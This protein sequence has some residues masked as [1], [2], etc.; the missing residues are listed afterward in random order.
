MNA[1][2]GRAAARGVSCKSRSL[3]AAGAALLVCG[4]LA[5][6]AS[7]AGGAW[8]TY[9]S[10]VHNLKA[11]ESFQMHL[12]FDQIPVRSWKL[13]IEGDQE[14]CDLSVL[15]VRG[16]ALVY[17]RIDESRHEVTVPWGRDEEAI[18]VVT[19]RNHDASFTVSV[20]G[21]PRDQTHAAYGYEVNR[22]LDA[23][24][25]GRRLD[26]EEHCR[27]ALQDDPDDGVA[28]VLLAGFLRERRLLDEAAALVDEA[29]AGD[30]PGDMRDVAE[31]LRDDL[32]RL[33]APL[34]LP[35]QQG[36]DKAESALRDQKPALALVACDD[37]LNGDLEL[38]AASRGQLLNLRGRALA[39]LDRNFE[40]LDAFTQALTFTRDRRS[41]AVVYHAM[42]DLFLKIG[43][44]PQADSS[45]TMALEIGLP[46]GL[47]LKA[48]ES[49]QDVRKRL[50]A[51]R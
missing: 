38:D 19:N 21:P 6:V 29:L 13:L 15:R 20:L 26:A 25:A 48:R 7:A 23:F 17:Y 11:R 36:V 35:V 1:L 42:G 31:G 34:P 8:E 43:N 39:G 24:A 37:L 40:A 51:E 18:L 32:L 46:S 12:T 4:L 44:L 30:L 47:D 2:P 28:K 41:E 10:E 50:A 22:A 14:T 16:E 9:W 33:R 49:L 27:N 3:W 45:Y 5:G